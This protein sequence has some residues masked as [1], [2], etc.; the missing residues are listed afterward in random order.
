MCSKTSP[1]GE[2]KQIPR[3]SKRIR[4]RKHR[5]S[6]S[7]ENS[8]SNP[9]ASRKIRTKTKKPKFLSLKLELNTSQEISESPGTAKSKKTNQKKPSKQSKTEGADDTAPFKEKKRPETL[10]GE[11]EEEQYDTVAAYLFNSTTDSTISSI[12]DLLPSSAADVDC[13]EGRNLSP[14]DRREH[15]SSSSSLLRTAMRKGAS[16]EEET[17]EE[18]WVSY[19][20]VVEEVMSRSG[21]PRCYGGDGNE[22]RPS[23]TLKLDYEH[24]MEVWSDKGTLY[25]D[26]EP[27]QTVPDLHASADVSTHLF[28]FNLYIIINA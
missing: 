18:R 10:G 8:S 7:M 26:G 4:K 9:E 20:E 5:E 16:E 1:V 14:Y 13:S 15:G 28:F 12:H 22:G 17:T 19:S 21:T 27:P 25:V 6:T 11:K 3:T 23:L 24:I 2:E